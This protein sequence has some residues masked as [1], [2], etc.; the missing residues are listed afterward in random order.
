MASRNAARGQVGMTL[1]EIMIVL[2]IIA[3]VMG[4]LVGPK[5]LQSM[6]E[7]KIKTARMMAKEYVGAYAQ[8]SANSE[9]TCPAGLE[10]LKKYRNKQDDKDPWGTK[11]EMRCGESAPEDNDFGVVSG[12]PDKKIGS[13]DDIKSWD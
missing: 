3:L 9:E 10:D 12:G 5:V 1:I 13:T 2:A 8:W 4:V 6:K 7:A 11:F